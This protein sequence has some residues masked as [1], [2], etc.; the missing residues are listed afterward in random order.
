MDFGVSLKMGFR[1]CSREITLNGTVVAKFE[2]SV[3]PD[4]SAAAASRVFFSLTEG[5]GEGS[6]GH[7][8]ERWRKRD[9]DLHE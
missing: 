3:S 5:V 1:V 6:K 2:F 4:L 9:K 7:E 8:R